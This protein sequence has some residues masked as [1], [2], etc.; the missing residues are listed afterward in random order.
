MLSA[1]VLRQLAR[2]VGSD[3]VIHAPEELIVYECDGYTIDKACPEAVVLPASTDEVARV[4]RL[5][6]RERIPFV[7]RGAGTGLSGGCLAVQGGVQ[8]ALTRMS[9]I[10]EVD[11]RNRRALVEAGVVN[12]H[13]TQAVSQRGYAYAPDPS[14]QVAS[15]IGGN[16]AENS[17][18]PHTLKYGV[19]ANHVL[20]LEM[21]LP[22]GE[23]VWLGERSGEAP[24]YDLRGAVIGSE[25][26]FGVVTRALVRLIRQPQAFRTLLAVYDRV[27]DASETVSAIIGRGIIPAALEMMDSL[28][29]QAVEDACACGLARDADAV[30]IIELDGLE[31][32]MDG[33]ARAVQTI[34]RERGARAV[35]LA[36]DEGERSALWYG[37]KRAFGS[38][39]RLSPS[40]CTQD[41]VIPRSQVAPVL[42][43]VAAIA[44]RHNLRIGNVFHAGDGNLHPVVLFDE[45]DAD[46]VR[47][48]LAAGDE[49]LRLCVAKGGSITGEHG[50]GTE[51][52]GMMPSLFTAA[53]L[54]A[55]RR[56]HAAFDP[57][58]LCNPGKVL[59]PPEPAR[60]APVSPGARGGGSESWLAALGAILPPEALLTGEGAA[61]DAV[62]GVTP[63]AVASPETV[64]QVC[65]VLRLAAEFGLGVCPVGAGLHRGLGHPPRRYDLALSLRR[66]CGRIEHEPAEMTVRVDAGVRL[67][68]LNRKLAAS[69]QWLPLDP[70]GADD[71]EASGGGTIGGILAADASGPSRLA[72][73]G[74]RDLLLALTIALADGTAVRSGARVVKNVAGFDLCR[75]FTGSLGTLG[76]I[77][78]ATVKV[79]PLPEARRTVAIRCRDPRDA[80]GVLE[81]AAGSELLPQHAEL[82]NPPAMER[83][84]LRPSWVVALSFDG[85]AETVAWQVAR[86]RE[87]ARRCGL[88]AGESAPTVSQRARRGL[89]RMV[90]GTPETVVCRASVLSSRVPDLL[91]A[92]RPEWPVWAHALLGVVR[93][94]LPADG[95]AAAAVSRAREQAAALGGV[96]VV[97][98][99]PFALKADLDVWGPVRPDFR[100]A[101]ALKGR[102]DP[103]G[104]LNPGRF[105]G[106][107]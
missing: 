62:D 49:I 47:R 13:V 94:V 78:E 22:D 21:V 107:L 74:P 101:R 7:A 1:R 32:G 44:R 23:V 34:C 67:P 59:P 30:L 10:L 66:L 83:L 79:A 57:S 63:C 88:Q 103:G 55:M 42:R 15:T 25:G 65:A 106:N 56:L 4:V 33:Q 20:G 82:V 5:C 87:L 68:D 24:G 45:R 18:G 11:L 54:D 73:G 80:A 2:I 26:T 84:G 46:E 92:F 14:S 85:P 58:G 9:R 100:L 38:V 70:P 52:I 51:K 40:Y 76:V 105:V 98:S 50:I 99:A 27:D 90:L 96:L 16:I 71:P 17:G 77:V 36:A 64:E 86:A 8:I 35:R 28:F 43:E 37:R 48:V 29:V 3:Q 39:G 104:I 12:I 69:G 6:H 61:G 81:R 72:C 93:V 53:D 31:A 95:N 60:E 19:T 75:V 91:P 41:G 89:G 102:F 97:E